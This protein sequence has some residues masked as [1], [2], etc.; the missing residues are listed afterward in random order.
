MPVNALVKVIAADV[1]EDHGLAELKV[2]L[3]VPVSTT[4]GK[5]GAVTAP[6]NVAAPPVAMV[7]RVS[8]P[9]INLRSGVLLPP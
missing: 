1:P 3:T 7:T 9:S 8:A 6:A 4:A 2:T 5:L